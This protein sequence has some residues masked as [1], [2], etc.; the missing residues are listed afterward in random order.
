M[1]VDLHMSSFAKP[2]GQV[3]QVASRNSI[4]PFRLFVLVEFNDCSWRAV[5][6]HIGPAFVMSSARC[7]NCPLDLPKQF[8]KG[9]L[10]HY[11]YIYETSDLDA[12]SLPKTKAPP[13]LKGPR[14]KRPHP[15]QFLPTEIGPMFFTRGDPVFCHQDQEGMLQ[16]LIHNNRTSCYTIRKQQLLVP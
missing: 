4:C 16:G 15:N 7:G 3:W 6:K 5:W 14:F 10:S 9:E 1:Q 11:I 12:T 2:L 8:L 13:I